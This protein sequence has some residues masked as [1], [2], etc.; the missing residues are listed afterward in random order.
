MN[1]NASWRDN[2]MCTQADP[3]LFFPDTG[4]ST[5]EAQGICA[6]CKSEAQ[7]LAYALDT[8]TRDGIWGG[9]TEQ[10]LR[11]LIQ[12]RRAEAA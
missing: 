12:A 2:A 8:G 6:S 1:R 3:D 4:G 9:H 5:A 11:R 10:E 7:C